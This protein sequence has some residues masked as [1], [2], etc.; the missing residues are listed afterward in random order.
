MAVEN[1]IG[2]GSIPLN[3]GG[4]LG[5]DIGNFLSTNLLGLDFSGLIDRK[6]NTDLKKLELQYNAQE[7][8]KNRDFQE[9]M[10]NTA[11]Q[12]AVEDL[13]KAGLNPVLAANASASTPSGA[14]ASFAAGNYTS[15]QMYNLFGEMLKV[16]G[17]IIGSAAGK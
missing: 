17:Q 3:E 11:Y 15:K 14:T 1:D 5:A 2:S 16:V 12:R 9:R 13:K 4:Y 10:S 7:A 8:Q 6:Y